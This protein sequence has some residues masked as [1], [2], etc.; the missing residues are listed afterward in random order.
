MMLAVDVHYGAEGATA[1]GVAFE[2]WASSAP[3]SSFVSHLPAVAE[4]RPGAFYER[5]L[6]CLLSLLQQSG[7]QPDCI[8]VDGY[9]YLD[10]HARP[11]LGKHLFDALNGR[12]P[13]IGVAKTAFD[14]IGPEFQILRGS[15]RRPLYVTCAGESLPIAKAKVQA[16]H[17]AHRMPTLLKAVDRLSRQ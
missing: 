17:G 12:I 1:A 6:P 7:L 15:S 9:V 16:M 4:Y 10:G 3:A 8:L 2:D 13:V 14:G 11:G 5:E